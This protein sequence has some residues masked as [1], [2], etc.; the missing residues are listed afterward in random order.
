M[1]AI[2]VGALFTVLFGGLLLAVYLG[3]RSVEEQRTVRKEEEQAW[4]FGLT[5]SGA[6]RLGERLVTA[7]SESAVKPDEEAMVRRVQNYIE[8]EQTLA[9]QFVSHPSVESLYR[10]SGRKSA[11]N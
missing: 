1:E 3:F 5:G 7:A 11:W 9:D 8:S 2:V 6:T 4:R 10:E